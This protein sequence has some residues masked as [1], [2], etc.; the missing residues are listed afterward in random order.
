MS[1]VNRSKMKGREN[2]VQCKFISRSFNFI[3]IFKM[4][5]CVISLWLFWYSL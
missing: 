1:R 5:K 3:F 4:Y 2:L